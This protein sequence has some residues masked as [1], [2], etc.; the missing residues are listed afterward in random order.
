VHPDPL[1]DSQLIPPMQQPQLEAPSPLSAIAPAWHTIVLIAAVLAISASGAARLAAHRGSVHTFATYSATAAMELAMLGWVALGLRLRK[2]PLRSLLGADFF[3]PRALFI[4]IGI[5]LLFWI[6]SALL[7]G[8][9]GLMWT[10]VQAAVEHRN[11]LAPSPEQQ[12]AVHAMSQFAPS[13]G[14]QIAAWILLCALVGL[15]EEIVFRGYLQT[16]FIRWTR[17]AV[18]AGI[19]FSALVF[20]AGHGY[21]GLRNMILLCVFGALFSGLVVFRRGLRAAVF[22]HSWHDL[23]TGLALALLKSHHLI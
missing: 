13:N 23:I 3:R 14:A 8:S 7:L 20:G 12:Q 2:I 18:S 1:D 21:Q 11:P 17:G 22:A 9:I 19:V 6:G 15:C 5:A 4:D 16:Q 10:I